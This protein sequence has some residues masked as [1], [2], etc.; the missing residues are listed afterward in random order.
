MM[1]WAQGSRLESK[2]MLR[3][4]CCQKLDNMIQELKVWGMG[5]RW[6]THGEF[7]TSRNLEVPGEGQVGLY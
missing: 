6:T 5:A 3:T 7:V 2:A 4:H 1:T